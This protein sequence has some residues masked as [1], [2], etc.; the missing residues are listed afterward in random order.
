MTFTE[1]QATRQW[2]NDISKVTGFDVG[3]EVA[4]YVYTSDFHIFALEPNLD[5]VRE[6][7]LVILQD[8]TTSRDLGALERKLFDWA[9]D[10]FNFN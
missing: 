1:F 4:G 5:G 8:V 2:T 3:T 10:D 9:S 6:F 7:Q